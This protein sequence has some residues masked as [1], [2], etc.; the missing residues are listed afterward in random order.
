MQI[1]LFGEGQPAAH[2]GVDLHRLGEQLR[3]PALRLD[4]PVAGLE[5]AGDAGRAFQGPVVAGLPPV[6]AVPP[7]H[8]RFYQRVAVGYPPVAGRLRAYRLV[9]G[10]SKPQ[11]DGGSCGDS[12]PLLESEQLTH[13]AADG[14]YLVAVGALPPPDAVPLSVA[15]LEV[16]GNIHVAAVARVVGE[17]LH[18]LPETASVVHDV[19]GESELAFEPVQV[20]VDARRFPMGIGEDGAV[21][22]AVE[23]SRACHDR[24]LNASPPRLMTVR[25]C[26]ER[27]SPPPRRRPEMSPREAGAACP[28]RRIWQ[29]G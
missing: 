12:L 28:S 13:L 4:P 27:I 9:G 16:Y 8:A 6:H 2:V 14:P 19:Q 24:G 21:R 29:A 20:G 23:R 7:R 5:G 11:L 15:S 1:G 18:V 3:P 17:G 26:V 25:E 22:G 10:Y